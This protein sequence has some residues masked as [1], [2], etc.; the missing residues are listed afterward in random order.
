MWN[1]NETTEEPKSTVGKNKGLTLILDGHTNLIAS[2]T[3]NDDLQGFYAL[4]DEPGKY[5][6]VNEGSTILQSGHT[7]FVAISATRY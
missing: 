3:I 4:V 2:G 5:P 6:L 7:S 1:N